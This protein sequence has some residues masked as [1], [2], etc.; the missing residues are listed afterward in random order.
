MYIFFVVSL[1]CININHLSIQE[2]F[3]L[4]V[5]SMAITVCV[6]LKCTMTRLSN[7]QK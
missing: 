3:T 5:G 1:C 6:Q 4:L 7:G 2:R